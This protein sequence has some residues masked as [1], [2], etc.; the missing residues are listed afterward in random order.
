MEIYVS[1]SENTKSDGLIC[2]KQPQASIYIEQFTHDKDSEYIQF[3]FKI[4]SILT[5]HYIA[6]NLVQMWEVVKL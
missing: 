1:Y 3:R 2:S 6:S 4:L 5:Q